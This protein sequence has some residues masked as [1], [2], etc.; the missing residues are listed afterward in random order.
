[1]KKFAAVVAAS[2]MAATA[3]KAPSITSGGGRLGH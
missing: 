3:A 1:M 2:A